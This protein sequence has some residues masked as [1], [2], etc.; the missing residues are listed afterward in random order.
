MEQTLRDLIGI[1]GPCGYEHDV[2]RYLVG[3][4]Q[5]STD[6][7]QVDGLGNVIVHKKGGHPGPK[8]VVSVHMDEVGFIVKK[9]ESNGLIRFEKLGG[10][11][12][13]ILLAQ[14]VRVQTDQ[15]IRLGVIGTIS[16]HM[17]RFDDPAKV[18]KHTELYIDVGAANAAEVAEMGIRVGDPISWATEFE[19]IGNRRVVG[20]AFDDRAG[21]A[22]LL[23][24]L[25]EI[26][27]ED[28]HGEVYG[29]FSVQEEVGLRGA[30][31][32]G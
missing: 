28:V 3:R 27:F 12:D 31:V 6:A 25:E 13:R 29:V 16:A 11:D 8:L 15:G 30:K 5:K 4:L 23:E 17:V 24:A 10:H 18:R 22:V 32:A 20:K 26:D 1:T 21:C 9:I 2:V 14:K 7:Y 19:R